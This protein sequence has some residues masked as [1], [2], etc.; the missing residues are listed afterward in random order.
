MR[1][2]WQ[3]LLHVQELF[4]FLFELGLLERAALNFVEADGVHEKLGAQNPT[5]LA[6]VQFGYEN[7]LVSLENFT[8]VGW[9]W[10]QMAQME[11]A[12][13]FAAVE[14]FT[15]RLDSRGDGAMGG[16]PGD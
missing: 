14:P 1:S 5:K 6:H 15:L 9:Q 16:T 8:D 11:M 7:F 10:I 12:D 2:G 4:D 13:A 3:L